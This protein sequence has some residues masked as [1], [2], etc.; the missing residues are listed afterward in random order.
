MFNFCS[1]AQFT[2]P[3]KKKIPNI[4]PDYVG[5]RRVFK[6]F[7]GVNIDG[8]TRIVQKIPVMCALCILLLTILN[9]TCIPVL[10]ENNL[11]S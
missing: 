4:L 11:T 8:N 3:S 9:Q 1:D 10:Y 2:S 5:T 6:I 7:C